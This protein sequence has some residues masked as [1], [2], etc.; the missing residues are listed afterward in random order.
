[1]VIEN[2]IG[3]RVSILELE[4]EEVKNLDEICLVSKLRYGKKVMSRLFEVLLV[5]IL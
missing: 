1:L 3:L 2:N 4:L 5:Q